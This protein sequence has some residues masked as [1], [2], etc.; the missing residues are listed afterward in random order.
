MT[1]KTMWKA[2]AHMCDSCGGFTMQQ[3][4]DMNRK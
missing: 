3:H 2:F 1:P 4:R